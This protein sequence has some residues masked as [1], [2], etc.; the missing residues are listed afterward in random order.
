MKLGEKRVDIGK[1]NRVV[2]SIP[3][4]QPQA[5]VWIDDRVLRANLRGNVCKHRTA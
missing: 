3:L 5:R 1:R 2:A 4:R